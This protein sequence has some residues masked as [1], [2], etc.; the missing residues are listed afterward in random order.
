MYSIYYIFTLLNEDFK[1]SQ[2]LSAGNRYLF[3]LNYF[4]LGG[5]NESIL[6]HIIRT[7]TDNSSQQIRKNNK[8]N[9]KLADY[10]F[11]K[12]EEEEDEEANSRMWL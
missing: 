8:W 1:V 6:V 5:K 2:R 4:F 9:P 12:E 7:R 10:Y 3:V 11:Q